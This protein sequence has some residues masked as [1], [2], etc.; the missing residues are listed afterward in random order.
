MARSFDRSAESQVVRTRS[1]A[2]ALVQSA[3]LRP[4]LLA[5]QL[6]LELGDR[7]EVR[8][9]GQAYETRRVAGAGIF[10]ANRLVLCLLLRSRLRH[11]ETAPST[12]LCSCDTL[13]AL[14]RTIEISDHLDGGIIGSGDRVLDIASTRQNAASERSESSKWS[15]YRTNFHPP[16][17]WA[18]RRSEWIRTCA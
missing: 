3:E 10:G 9:S 4:E 17:T 8:L 14:M 12:E 16:L 6:L 5:P 11:G 15:L 13:H 18:V 2:D 1:G 7:L